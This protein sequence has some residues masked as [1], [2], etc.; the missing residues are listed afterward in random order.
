MVPHPNLPALC[1]QLQYGPCGDV[2]GGLGAFVELMF[3]VRWCLCAR[4]AD[5]T[6]GVPEESAPEPEEASGARPMSIDL[7]GGRPMSI[8]M[9]PTSPSMVGGVPLW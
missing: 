7:G 6:G 1:A 3:V 9:T 5:P 2:S 8:D 4:Q